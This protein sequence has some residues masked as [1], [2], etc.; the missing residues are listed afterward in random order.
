MNTCIPLECLHKW[1]KA[2]AV[3]LDVDSTVITSEGLDDLAE[4]C[5]SGQE[6]AKWTAKAMGEGISFR[7]SLNLRLNI[8]KPSKQE[9]EDFLQRRPPSLTDNVKELSDLL[10]SKG[11]A[12]YL[13][14]GGFHAIVDPI[15]DKLQVPLEKVFANRM[16]HDELGGYIGFSNDEPTSESYG[17]A[18]VVQRLK[19]EFGYKTLV[20]I[21][22]GMTDLEAY[23]PAD[24]FI[25]FGANKVRKNV[26]EKAPWFVKSFQELIDA[27]Q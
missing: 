22:D 12:V 4:F 6:V 26:Q 5:G 27:A 17:K 11:T 16:L 13:I 20:M 21:G 18:R 1:K 24:L 3:C 14:S 10:S 7:E 15:A 19:N 9:L 23:P 8:F 2:D 25:G